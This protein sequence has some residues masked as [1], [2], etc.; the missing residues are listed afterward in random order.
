M[1]QIK[2][3][4][5]KANAILNSVSRGFMLLGQTLLADLVPLKC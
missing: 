4:E 2:P 1:T 5:A 3:G